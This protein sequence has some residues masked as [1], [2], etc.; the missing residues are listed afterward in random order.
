MRAKKIICKQCGAALPPGA[1]ECPYCGSAYAPE[2]ER[3]YM[4][5]LHE[6]KEDLD[7]VGDAGEEI[8]KKEISRSGKKVALIVGSILVIAGVLFFLF[9]GFGNR[10]NARNR[11]EYQWR[12]EHLGEMDKLFEEG[13]YDALLEAFEKAREED[14]DLYSWDHYN[15][16]IYWGTIK[17]TDSALLA[18]EGGYF[19]EGDAVELLYDELRIRAI[20]LIKK[21]PAK[22][23]E[24]LEERTARYKDDLTEIFFFT[25]EDFEYFD[26]LL[27]KRDGYPAYKDCKEYVE[28]HPE[29][30][31]Q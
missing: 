4:R 23:R 26:N 21:L 11:R 31:E 9:T 27:Q 30:W 7:D 14:H 5:K 17:Y 2:A 6:I 1:A 18:R 16:C 25:Q 13:D 28:K 8:S 19:S 10:E 22:D 12:Q 24:I 20:P 15:F 3:E 29:I